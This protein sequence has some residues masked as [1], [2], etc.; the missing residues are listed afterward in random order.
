MLHAI[1]RAESQLRLGA[2]LAGALQAKINLNVR[3]IRS[4]SDLNEDELKA[5]LS[6]SEAVIQEL[7]LEERTKLLAPR[8]ELK[9]RPAG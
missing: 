5:I 8:T 2:E 3:V 6:E 9:S 4:I 1:Q 7:P